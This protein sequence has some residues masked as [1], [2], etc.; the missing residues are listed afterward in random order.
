MNVL[1]VDDE[2]AILDVFKMEI[3]F[4]YEDYIIHTATDGVIALDICKNNK[5]DLILT[6]GKMPN[7]DGIEF[8]R[9]L[10]KINY[11]ATI[12]M[13]TGHHN[14]LDLSDASKIGISKVLNKPIKFDELHESIKAVA[15][16]LK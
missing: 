11:P 5:I 6:D 2:E 8:S 15:D 12:I 1:L 14:A 16:K 4:N 10:K 13:I 3:E 7:M 9:E